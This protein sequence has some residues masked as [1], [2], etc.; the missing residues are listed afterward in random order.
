MLIY[1]FNLFYLTDLAQNFLVNKAKTKFLIQCSRGNLLE[2]TEEI[3]LSFVLKIKLSRQFTLLFLL[4]IDFLISCQ[5]SWR[6]SNLGL[7]SVGER[8]HPFYPTLRKRMRQDPSICDQG[9]SRTDD[10]CV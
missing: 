10:L 1:L 8:C 3:N 2:N 7:S 9:G 4:L 5:P 6:H